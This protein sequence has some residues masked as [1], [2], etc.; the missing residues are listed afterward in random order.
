LRPV[1]EAFFQPRFSSPGVH[2]RTFRISALRQDILEAYLS[3]GR[4]S[5]I[6]QTAEAEPEFTIERDGWLV[7]WKQV[8]LITLK[9]ELLD[10][11]AAIIWSDLQ[12][13][14]RVWWRTIQELLRSH[15][16]LETPGLPRPPPLFGSQGRA[17]RSQDP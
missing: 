11:P 16:A 6:F 1:W 3:F 4:E 2:K 9:I 17:A 13:S 7:P 12:E 8:D 10:A 14:K 15:G 5:G